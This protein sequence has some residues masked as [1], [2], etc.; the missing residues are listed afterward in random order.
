MIG[1]LVAIIIGFVDVVG[2]GWVLGEE[3]DN[4]LEGVGLKLIGEFG[5]I[6]DEGDS[7]DGGLP[8]VL[9]EF[10][11]VWQANTGNLLGRGDVGWVFF[12]VLIEGY[13]SW[14]SLVSAVKIDELLDP[15]SQSDKVLVLP[16]VVKWI[17]GVEGMEV[18]E[19]AGG[20]IHHLAN[21]PC[22]CS[23]I[24]LIAVGNSD[25]TVRPVRVVQLSGEWGEDELV[26][27][28]PDV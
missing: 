19:D 5:E 17:R 4:K 6:G 22:D 9:N 18:R 2:K 15:S 1:D 12:I 10:A 16:E 7:F 11:H 28:G 23:V 3:V 13:S 26:G 27:L 8:I 20:V 24:M 21:E 25:K 14:G